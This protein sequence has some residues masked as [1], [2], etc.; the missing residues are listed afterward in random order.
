MPS[1]FSSGN[2]IDNSLSVTFCLVLSEK[3]SYRI[4]KLEEVAGMSKI[5]QPP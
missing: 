2:E 3:K 1:I 4:N 5:P